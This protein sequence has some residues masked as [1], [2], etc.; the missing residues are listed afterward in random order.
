MLIR[1]K[2]GRRNLLLSLLTKTWSWHL[3]C[4]I[5]LYPIH[6]RTILIK[7]TIPS[8]RATYPLLIWSLGASTRAYAYPPC[9][10]KKKKKKNPLLDHALDFPILPSL[11]GVS[12]FTMMDRCTQT[13]QIVDPRGL[14]FQWPVMLTKICFLVANPQTSVFWLRLVEFKAIF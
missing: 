12:L 3:S 14:Q 4:N 7:L 11:L 8:Y 2:N 9:A 10:L 5:P 6:A 1:V 13:W